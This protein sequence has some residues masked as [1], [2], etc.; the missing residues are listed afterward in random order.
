MRTRPILT[1]LAVALVVAACGGD[2][3][4]TTTTAPEAATTTAA[5]DTTTTAPEAT[6]TTAA[7]G[8]DT[9][10]ITIADFSFGEVPTVS[11]GDTV[12]VENTDGA[13]HTWT[14]SDGTF[15]SGTLGDGDT[16]E[17]T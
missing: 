1:L 15:D 17:F 4:D 13:G 9:A 12:V 3:S 6:T 16:F 2:T 8:G 7:T 14:A 11:V 5:G 10:T